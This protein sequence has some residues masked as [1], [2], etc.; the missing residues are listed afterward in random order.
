[1]A[2][3]SIALPTRSI[4]RGRPW[5]TI[6]LALVI[7]DFGARFRKQHPAMAL[8]TFFEPLILVVLMGSLRIYIYGK[9]PLFGTSVFLFMGAGIFPFYA[10][11]NGSNGVRAPKGRRMEYYFVKPFD[12]I[13]AHFL[14]KQIQILILMAIFFGGLWLSGVNEAIPYAPGY[15]VAGF[16]L[17]SLLAFGIGLGN[18]AIRSYFEGWSTFYRLISRPMMMFSGAFKTVDLIPEPAH[19]IFTWNPISHGIELFRLGIY[20]NYPVAS[21]DVTYLLKWVVGSLLVGTLMFYNRAKD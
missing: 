13:V 4:S 2:E 14:I 11:K 12:Y 9:V 15:C 17:L 8:L 3:S 10:F 6:I 18:A 19:S 16:V 20:P 1:M 21:M 7:R 5:G